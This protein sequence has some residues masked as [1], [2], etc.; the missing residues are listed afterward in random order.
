[1]CKLILEI[2]LA[3]F[4]HP[5]AFILALINITGRSDLSTLQ[6]VGWG[7]IS[8]VWGIGPILYMVLADG[9]LW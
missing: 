2:L 7:V 6:K 3:I 4:L 5:L 1:M 9:E 8:V